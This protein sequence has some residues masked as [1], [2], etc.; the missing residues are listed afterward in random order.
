MRTSVV[1]GK[2]LRLPMEDNFR[3]GISRY[4]S[5][6]SKVQVNTPHGHSVSEQ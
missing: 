3:S 5:A 2:Y 6:M 4:Q 1:A